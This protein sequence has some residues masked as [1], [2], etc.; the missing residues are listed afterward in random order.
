MNLIEIVESHDFNKADYQDFVV[1]PDI[2]KTVSEI[3]ETVRKKGDRSLF[4]YTDKFDKVSLRSLKIRDEEILSARSR[5]SSD[6]MTILNEAIDNIRSFHENQLQES[7]I[8]EH[9]DGTK[10]GE[11]VRP[12]DRVGLYIPGGTAPLFSTVLMLAIPARIAQCPEVVL[13][14]PAVPAINSVIA[15]KSATRYKIRWAL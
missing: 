1:K 14:T 12:L 5:I 15:L 10:L 9:S 13:C 2:Q 3:I 7:W 8:K 11:L 4:D 6:I